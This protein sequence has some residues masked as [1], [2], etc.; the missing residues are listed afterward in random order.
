MHVHY[1]DQGHGGSIKSTEYTLKIEF[2][3][4]IQIV[5]N[6]SKFFLHKKAIL[7]IVA[8]A[9][10]LYHMVVF[11]RKKNPYETFCKYKKIK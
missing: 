10:N 6:H 3:G 1:S 2:K 9:Q 7:A 4:D 5:I 11:I 8:Y